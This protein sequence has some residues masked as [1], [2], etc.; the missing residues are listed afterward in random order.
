ML[1][2]GGSYRKHLAAI[3]AARTACTA[4]G[5]QVLRP[6]SAEVLDMGGGVVRMVG[7]PADPSAVEER[8]LEAIRR[9]ELLYVVNPGGY[10]G[11]SVMLEIGFAIG[12]GIPVAFAEPPFEPSAAQHAW[13]IGP[14]DRAIAT[15]SGMR[16]LPADRT[17]VARIRDGDAPGGDLDGARLHWHGADRRLVH[18]GAAIAHLEDVGIVVGAPAE[19]GY[20]RLAQSAL[21]AGVQ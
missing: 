3:L 7:D 13:F 18:A 9:S 17:L 6:A 20:G 10:C 16:L 12:R 14:P 19:D 5:A 2:I 4:A 8:Q 1:T 21:G 11:S 15:L